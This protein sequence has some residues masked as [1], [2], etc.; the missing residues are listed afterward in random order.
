M[1]AGVDGPKSLPAAARTS[2]TICQTA[3]KANAERRY[4]VAVARENS[5][6]S[7]SWTRSN[8]PRAYTAKTRCRKPTASTAPK[9]SG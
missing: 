9:V 4:R 2:P 7:A 6:P 8:A 3:A 1:K 5:E